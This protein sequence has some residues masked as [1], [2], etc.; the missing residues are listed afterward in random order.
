MGLNFR[1]SSW[2]FLKFPPFPVSPLPEWNSVSL[3]NAD[4]T[5]SDISSCP[6]E[7]LCEKQNC[8]HPVTLFGKLFDVW[9]D[10]DPAKKGHL[11]ELVQ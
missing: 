5:L 6:G 1:N 8:P 4:F 9:T 3:I 7:D 10:G 2:C 11:M